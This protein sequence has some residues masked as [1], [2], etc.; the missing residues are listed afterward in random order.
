MEKPK[1]SQDDILPVHDGVVG[2]VLPA[3]SRNAEIVAKRASRV[4]LKDLN[5]DGLPAAVAGP[6]AWPSPRPLV[7]KVFPQPGLEMISILIRYTTDE[8][9]G[10]LLTLRLWEHVIQVSRVPVSVVVEQVRLRL[11]ASLTTCICKFPV[12]CTRLLARHDVAGFRLL[13]A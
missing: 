9:Q 5:A 8:G 10:T 7:V 6:E 1:K 4:G 13:L 12:R 2:D 11:H 3:T